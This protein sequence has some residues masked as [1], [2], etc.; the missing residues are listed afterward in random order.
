[1][2]CPL[3]SAKQKGPLVRF[4]PS[5]LV[6]CRALRLDHSANG[7]RPQPQR[8][9]SVVVDDVDVVGKIK[10]L[11]LGTLQSPFRKN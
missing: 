6:S 8:R 2:Q 1:M 9:P 3:G 4:K 7:R 11:N 10:C 5:S